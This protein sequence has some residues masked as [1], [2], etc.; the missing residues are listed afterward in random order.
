MVKIVE[1]L[2]KSGDISPEI[3]EKL[4]KE[5]LTFAEE[6]NKQIK[7]LGEE[8]DALAKN[9]EEVTKSKSELDKQLASIDERIEQ[10]KRDGQT[11]LTKQ[12]EAERNEKKALQDS[13][14]SLKTANTNLTLDTAVS[15]A[16]NAF[17]IRKEDR[18]L[19][20]FR[21]RA[22][23][24]LDENGNAVY[25][26]GTPIQDAFSLYFEQNPSRLNPVGDGNGSGAN[27]NTGGGS[28]TISRSDFEKLPPAK[29]AEAAK[30]MKITEG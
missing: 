28:K 18:D 9:Y 20:E 12:L 8:K 22:E 17:D 11:E 7:A 24:K 21:L 5:W 2:Q 4:N 16:L 25:K 30:T 19:V 27:S 29:K 26:D 15:Q 23:V 13:L 3:A 14:E 10:A 6:K 1:E